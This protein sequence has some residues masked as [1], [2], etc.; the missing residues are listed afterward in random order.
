MIQK[1]YIE[2]NLD[3][4]ID[5]KV[6]RILIVGD[7]NHTLLRQ[8]SQEM[9]DKF[10]ISIDVLSLF[11]SYH[12][13]H[14][15]F[16]KLYSVSLPLVTETNNLIKMKINQIFYYKVIKDIIKQLDNY[17]VI[18]IHYLNPIY[19]F[20]VNELRGKT[21]K[22]YVTMWGSD[23]YRVNDRTKNKLKRVFNSCDLITFTNDSMK[24][25]FLNY[26]EDY[27]QK[28]K[29]CRFGLEVLDFIDEVKTNKKLKEYKKKFFSKYD[30]D[31]Q[32]MIIACGYNSGPGQQHEKIID[33]IKLISNEKLEDVIFLFPMAYGDE[34][35]RKKIE[36]LLQNCEF[37]YKVLTDYLEGNEIALLREI[38]DIMI[39][40]Q[41]TDQ[42]S[43]SMQETLYAGN[44]LI[45]G[46]W[47][48]Y[49]TFK[50]EGAFFLE[51]NDLTELAEKLE[52]C[53][54]NCEDLKSKTKNNRDIIWNLSSWQNNSKDWYNLYQ[55]GGN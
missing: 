26:Y 27:H 5:N 14:K 47:L 17:D 1:K 31:S 4:Y 11:D 29:V 13:N 48:P 23:F 33:S 16:C 46:G 55:G 41:T 49:D 35:N 37:N 40:I 36:L 24:N 3:N 2:N 50:K 20:F 18:N 52:Y 21:S 19:R 8:L 51:V 34:E 45:N 43:G 38:S 12:R 53:I 44:I 9:K 10:S 54:D 39:N 6:Q 30:I 28:V 7:V 15:Y 25:D 22:L 32:K 42:F